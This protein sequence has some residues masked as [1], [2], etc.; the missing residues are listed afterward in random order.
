MSSFPYLQFW[1]ILKRKRQNNTQLIK[2]SSVILTP[3][4]YIIRKNRFVQYKF[5]PR[6][7]YETKFAGKH[8]CLDLY[9]L[10]AETFFF[11]RLVIER[12][13]VSVPSKIDFNAVKIRD[14]ANICD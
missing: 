7:G 10:H 12:L 5:H 9:L 13:N 4:V 6:S 8:W 14:W 3:E 1:T 11:D 2:N